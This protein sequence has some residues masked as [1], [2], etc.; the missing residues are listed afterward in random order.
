MPVISCPSHSVRSCPWGCL[1][2]FP[3]PR[4]PKLVGWEPTAGLGHRLHSLLSPTSTCAEVQSALKIATA[5]LGPWEELRRRKLDDLGEAVVSGLLRQ[6]RK[7]VE[8]RD[9]LGALRT[10]GLARSPEVAVVEKALWRSKKHL[11]R[12]RARDRMLRAAS[13]PRGSPWVMPPS[14]EGLVGRRQSTRTSSR[15]RHGP[16]WRS[17]GSWQLGMCS[18]A[19]NVRLDIGPVDP[20]SYLPSIAFVLALAQV[21]ME[22]RQPCSLPWALQL[23]TWCIVRCVADSEVRTVEAWRRSAAVCL[24]KLGTDRKFLNGWRAVTM[25]SPAHKLFDGFKTRAL[26]P[27]LRPLPDAILGSRSGLQPMDI[28]VLIQMLLCKWCEWRLPLAVVSMDVR[29]ASDRMRLPLVAA[30]LREA[31]RPSSWQHGCLRRLVLVSL[32]LLGRR[33]P[34]QSPS[35]LSASKGTPPPRCCGTSCSL[36]QRHGCRRSGESE[37]V[38]S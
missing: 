25:V 28:A 30:A 18:V 36:A 26:H 34:H 3:A 21:P 33:R 29:V 10:A 23:G 14:L 5:D 6:E 9:R 7:V 22:Y 38:G 31:P 13:R 17:R 32:S 16:P 24:P 27:H 37:G 4:A 8:L 1:A 11:R 19:A 20:P 2:G 15:T 12:W 35:R